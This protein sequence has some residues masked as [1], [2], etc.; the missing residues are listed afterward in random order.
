MSALV[1]IFLL[2]SGVILVLPAGCAA[3][4]TPMMFLS[5]FGPDPFGGTPGETFADLLYFV[6]LGWAITLGGVQLLRCA[7][8]GSLSVPAPR[9][10]LAA[11]GILLLMPGVSFLLSL[12]I[13]SRILAPT[14]PQQIENLI[15]IILTPVWVALGAYLLWRLRQRISETVSDTPPNPNP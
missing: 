14:N 9:W 4:L 10:M 11:A 5:A 15:V 3:A 6:P 12:G 1:R 7:N 2:V 13:M 8:R